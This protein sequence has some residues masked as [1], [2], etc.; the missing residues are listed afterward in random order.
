MS[1]VIDSFLARQFLKGTVDTNKLIFETLAAL[2]VSTKVVPG[3]LLTTAV[4][5]ARGMITDAWL[6][7]L[8]INL[9]GSGDSCDTTQPVILLEFGSTLQNDCNMAKEKVFLSITGWNTNV[10]ELSCNKNKEEQECIEFLHEY[11]ANHGDETWGFFAL[12]CATIRSIFDYGSFKVVAKTGSTITV[13]VEFPN[14]LGYVIVM[15]DLSVAIDDI[16]YIRSN[17]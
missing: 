17:Q 14:E 10:S 3:M 1:N 2:P 15:C 12:I 6:G 16:K 7:A 4:V 9:K 13:R 8:S 5:N 11:M